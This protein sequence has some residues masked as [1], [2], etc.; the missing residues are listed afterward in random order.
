MQNVDRGVRNAS[1]MMKQ[2]KDKRLNTDQRSNSLKRHACRT[3]AKERRIQN[4][5]QILHVNS[6][7]QQRKTVRHVPLP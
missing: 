1:A 2:G 7:F 3:A 6:S 4:K 5:I